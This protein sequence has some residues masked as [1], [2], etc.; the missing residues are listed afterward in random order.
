MR[1]I[2]TIL[3]LFGAVL[4]AGCKS[5]D[6]SP[7]AEVVIYTSV[8]QQVAEPILQQ[9]ERETGIKVRIFTDTEATKSAGLATRLLA[10]KGNPQADVFWG[11]EV[12][13]TINLARNGV[14]GA[15]DSPQRQTI[16]EQYKDPS[17]LWAGTCIRAR[18]IAVGSG[19]SV[20]VSINGLEDLKSPELKDRICL[21]RPTAG[22][23]GGHVSAI[24]AVWGNDKADAFFRAL[25]AN[26]AKMLGGN[27]V[28]AEQVG[29]GQMLAGL[30]DNDDIAAALR[31]GGKL[32]M[33][34]P[35]QGEA[36]MG[37]LT[38]PCT[39]AMVAGRPPSD[40]AKK[41]IDYLLSAEVEKKLIDA[42]FG[43]YS[44]RA[45]GDQA[46]RTMDVPYAKIAEN[47]SWAPNRA[48]AILEGREP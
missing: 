43:Q 40:A 44:V 18:V 32:G 6:A 19:A 36:G 1:F 47:M 35:D 21:A 25:H 42:R 33:V 7:A 15:Y 26:G 16:P 17:H 9:F 41:L 29:Q 45:T 11:N 14:L 31:A 5:D 24:Y 38:I 37:T 4:F 23:T 2:L 20:P 48:A 22:T 12:F 30:T 3:L 39:V 34:L 28:V 10:E 13:H 46:V 27:A 8:D